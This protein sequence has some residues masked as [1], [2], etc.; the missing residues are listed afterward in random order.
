MARQKGPPHSGA[1]SKARPARQPPQFWSGTITF[2]LVS[3]PIQML[4]AHRTK[5]T[6]LRELGTDGTP[7]RRRFY[8]PQDQSEV[9]LAQTVRGFEFKPDHYVVVTERELEALEPQKSREIDLRLFVEFAEIS[10]LLFERSY[11]LAPD[12][13]TTKAYRLLAR[14]LEDTRR[15]GIATFVMHDREYVVAIIAEDG[16]LRGQTLRFVDE[17]R[18]PADVGLTESV[19][20]ERGLLGRFERAIE[21]LSKAHIDPGELRDEYA[22][23]LQ[24]LVENKRRRGK[25]IVEIDEAAI[26]GEREEAEEEGEL[27]LLE[28]IR[29]SLAARSGGARLLTSSRRHGSNGEASHNGHHTPATQTRSHSAVTTRSKATRPGRKR[30]R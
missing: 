8:C 9:P 19:S 24:R 1:R 4:P 16:I 5:R 7:L 27:D 18:Q 22:E 15:G 29:K 13:D 14:V 20:A 30:G 3:V 11:Y 26:S 21:K 17:I 2:G 12:G 10:P 25:D 23:R 28:T 6:P